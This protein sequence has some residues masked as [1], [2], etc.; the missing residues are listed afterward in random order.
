MT[1]YWDVPIYVDQTEVRA[2][3]VDAR[4]V[5]INIIIDVIVGYSHETSDRVSN[6]LEPLKERDILRMKKVVL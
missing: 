3:R 1:A 2:N 6:F 4:F 5:D